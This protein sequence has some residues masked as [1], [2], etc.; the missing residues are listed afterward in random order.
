MSIA[1]SSGVSS[2]IDYSGLIKQLVSI[3]REPIN[4]MNRRV[5]ELEDKMS[6]YETL[7]ARLETMKSAADKL[8]TATSFQE[9][10]ATSSDESLITASSNS[11]ASNG[12]YSIVVDN[13]AQAHKIAADGVAA[14]TTVVSAAGGSFKFQ[15]GTGPEQT[16]T[17]AA[18]ATLDDL[19]NGINA[20]DG[21]AK[22]TLVNDGSAVD[23]V[24]LILTSDDT[25]ASSAVTIT[26]NDTTLAFNTTLQAALDASFKVDNLV[27]TRASNTVTDVISG[28]TFN[29]ESADPAKTVTLDVS[30]DESA[31]LSNLQLFVSSYNSMS[32]YIKANNRYDTETKIAQ[33]F[34]GESIARST[35]DEVRRMFTAPIAGRPESMQYLIQAGIETKEG[36]LTID[37]TKF[38][39]ALALN[40]DAII[41]LFTD[42]SGTDGFAN[43]LSD[44]IDGLT[45]FVDGRMTIKTKSLS[46][47]IKDLTQD[48]QEQDF[49]LALYEEGLRLQ[50]A[51]LEAMLVGFKSQ[52]TFLS[53]LQG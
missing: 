16:V 26:Q 30:R 41:D 42:D 39:E 31:I 19:R 52:S 5:Y 10:A 4:A 37:A 35:L 34:F 47:G 11:S 13:L 43:L 9:F 33:P 20:L 46:T 23:P 44:K 36:T 24:R 8:K 7:T 51:S 50:F 15:I 48:I 2:G 38:K 32:D 1:A 28:V 21:G 6:A 25:G 40:P 22:A 53:G 29:L 45:D 12:S 27:I 3:K 18:G 17:L 14:E 49:N